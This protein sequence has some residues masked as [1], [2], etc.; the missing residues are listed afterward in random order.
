MKIIEYTIKDALGI[1]SPSVEG[2]K[3]GYYFDAGV[4]EGITGNADMAVD[5][6]GDLGLAVYNGADDFHMGKFFGSN[7]C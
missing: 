7:V 6:A 2:E 4:A 3:L 1:H 5:A